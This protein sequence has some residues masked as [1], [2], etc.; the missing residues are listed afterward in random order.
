MGEMPVLINKAN[1]CTQALHSV[2]YHLLKNITPEFLCVFCFYLI[3]SIQSWIHFFHLKQQAAATNTSLIFYHSSFT[4]PSHCSLF[5]RTPQ[6]SW[7]FSL[8][9]VIFPFCLE[10]TSFRFL[11][12]SLHHITL[13]RVTSELYSAKST[14]HFSMPMFLDLL[15]TFH[16]VNHLLL[17]RF[18]FTCLPDLIVL[19]FLLPH[20]FLPLIS[21]ML[22][23]SHLL[24]L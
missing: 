17:K 18:S 6:K 22:V 5:S 13:L 12:L 11:L 8:F 19:F 10:F 7:L 21:K 20:Q 9:P 3:N 2:L 1:P 14:G 4:I 24:D 16:T 23:A 15:V